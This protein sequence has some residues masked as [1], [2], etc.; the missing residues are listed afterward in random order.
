M[1]SNTNPEL[2]IGGVQINKTISKSTPVFA[3]F[4][5]KNTTKF[6][7]SPASVDSAEQRNI[8][9]PTSKAERRELISFFCKENIFFNSEK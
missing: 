2:S 4:K 3:K 6:C 5:H 7:P 8:E 1:C 9:I